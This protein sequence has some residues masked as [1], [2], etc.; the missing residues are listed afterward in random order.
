MP[1]P[2]SPRVIYDVA[3]DDDRRIHQQA[4]FLIY[5]TGM[6]L[7]IGFFTVRQIVDQQTSWG[8]FLIGV[9][10]IPSLLL[11]LYWMLFGKPVKSAQRQCKEWRATGKYQVIEGVL[12]EFTRRTDFHVRRRLGRP[13]PPDYRCLVGG[14]SFT[15]S[16]NIVMQCRAGFQGLFTAPDVPDDILRE[17]AWVRIAF[18]EGYVLRIEVCSADSAK[19]E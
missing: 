4:N 15:W 16:D 17:G 14:K 5:L 19:L 6:G 3:D 18:R 8:K 13:P 10:V 11:G 9:T 2:G 12:S 1:P 7:I